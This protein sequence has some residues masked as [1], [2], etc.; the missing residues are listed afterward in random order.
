[1]RRLD[2]AQNVA[3]FPGG[4]TE[5]SGAQAAS[6]VFRNCPTAVLAFNDRCA[7]G[8]I[9]ALTIGGVD[10]PTN[11]SIIGFDNSPVSQLA[12]INLTTITHNTVR[13]TDLALE[14]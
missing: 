6:L 2:L 10:V 13:M 1:M 12:Q 3:V 11:T 9:D 8:L 5:K 4:L 14:A 7:I